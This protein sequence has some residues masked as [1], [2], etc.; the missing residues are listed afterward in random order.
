MQLKLNV[1]VQ[2]RYGEMIDGDFAEF[3][4]YEFDDDENVIRF[5]SELDNDDV[6]YA[7]LYFITSDDDADV[8]VFISSFKKTYTKT[9]TGRKTRWVVEDK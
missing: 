8:D 2:I 9:K 7:M 6:N 5:L 4:R 3:D 1:D